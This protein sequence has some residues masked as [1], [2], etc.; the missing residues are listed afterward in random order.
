LKALR[1]GGA[2]YPKLFVTK[3]RDPKSSFKLSGNCA[4]YVIFFDFNSAAARAAAP[5]RE[6]GYTPFLGQNLPLSIF[7]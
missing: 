4:R 1:F 3:I 6:R 7:F 5:D 2:R